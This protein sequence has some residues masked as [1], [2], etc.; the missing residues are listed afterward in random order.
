MLL[1]EWME[2]GC[3]REG[4]E[5]DGVGNLADVVVADGSIVAVDAW[6]NAEEDD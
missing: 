2:G 3:G 5:D 1:E 4:W 6:G